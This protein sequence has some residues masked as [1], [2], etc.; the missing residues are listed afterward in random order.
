MTPDLAVGVIIKRSSLQPPL[1]AT[2]ADGVL[3]VAAEEVPAIFELAFALLC[4]KQSA[5]IAHDH[6][7]SE[8]R[9]LTLTLHTKHAPCQSPPNAFTTVSVTGFLHPLHLLLYR[10]V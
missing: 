8:E 10:F 6:G 1:F 7:H 4:Y 3:R 2:N 5:Q 9:Q